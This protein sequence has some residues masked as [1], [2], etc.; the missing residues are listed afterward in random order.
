MASLVVLGGAGFIGQAVRSVIRA[1]GDEAIV[2][3]RVAGEPHPR[4]RWIVLDLLEASVAE[5]RGLVSGGSAQAV[6]NCA[7]VVAGGI[8]TQVRAN[9][10]VPARLV[11]AMNDL[12]PRLVH[13]GS[14]AEYGPGRMGSDLDERTSPRPVD[15]YGITKL[16]GTLL[17]EAATRDGRVDAVVMRLFN[18]LGPGMPPHSMPGRAARLIRE[19]Q[20]TGAPSIPLGPLDAW[21]DFID[22]RDAATALVAA[23]LAARVGDRVLNLGTGRALQAREVVAALAAAAGWDGSIVEDAAMGSPRSKGVA[24][25]RASTRRIQRALGW[26]PRYSLED[27]ARFVMA[28]TA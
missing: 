27:A 11:E 13:V 5:L 10:L 2:V 20:A 9:V 24:W 21:R 17:I 18:P 14:A 4:E 7:G 1:R 12:G 16:A 26:A 28:S 25:Q 3:D 23:A 15:P 22:V 8:E 19:A 6:I